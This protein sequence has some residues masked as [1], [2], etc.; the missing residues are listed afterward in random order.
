LGVDGWMDGWMDGWKV[1][2]PGLMDCLVQ[3]K[4]LCLAGLE[5]KTHQKIK[6]NKH[7]NKLPFFF[8]EF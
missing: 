6:L 7:L 3:S 8:E 2:K 1:V 4:T 5:M